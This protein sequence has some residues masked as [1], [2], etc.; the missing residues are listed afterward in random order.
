MS[1]GKKK[2]SR[3][4]TVT[5]K[6]IYIPHEL[7]TKFEK[8]ADKSLQLFS[9]EFR[10]LMKLCCTCFVESCCVVSL[11]IFCGKWIGDEKGR[12]SGNG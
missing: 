11:M 5:P 6:M 10:L 8:F 9:G 1:D 7:A 4:K 3:F 2:V 12:G